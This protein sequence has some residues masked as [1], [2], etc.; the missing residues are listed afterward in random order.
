[1]DWSE[2][3]KAHKGLEQ[4]QTMADDPS[5]TDE[6]VAEHAYE[7][8]TRIICTYRHNYDGDINRILAEQ[9]PQVLKMIE[10]RFLANSVPWKEFAETR[11]D[12]RIP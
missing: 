9:R 6:T 8:N 4:L 1:M 7:L 12:L 3:E 5:I 10:E 2:F 11:P